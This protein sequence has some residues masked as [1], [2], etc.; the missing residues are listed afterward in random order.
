[1]WPYPPCSADGRHWTSRRDARYL[2]SVAG[3]DLTEQLRRAL[4]KGSALP[5]ERIAEMMSA[6][7]GDGDGAITF[8]ELVELLR[9]RGLGGPFLCRV[10]AKGVWKTVED[11]VLHP[12]DRIPV[13]TVAHIFH[14]AMASSSRPDRRYKITPDAVRGLEPL[15]DLFGEPIERKVPP[16][17][18]AE[19]KPAAPAPT[20]PE[21]ASASGPRPRTAAPR[22]SGRPAPRTRPR[23]GAPMPRRSGPKPRS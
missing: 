22:L 11:R 13:E 12:V 17:A 16:S 5:A 7:D 3:L 15:Q 19:A 8:D 23:T 21:P 4:G 6:Q 20:A 18:P 1:M 9:Q 14:T 2:D 10:V